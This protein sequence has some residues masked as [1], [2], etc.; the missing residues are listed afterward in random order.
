MPNIPEFRPDLGADQVH[1]ALKNSIETMDKAQHCAL[2]WFGEILRRELYRNLGFSTM[3]SYA[4][5]ALG[6]SPTRAGDFIRLARKLESLP[7][8]KEQVATGKL[9]YT[10]AREIAS[11]ADP[12]NEKGWV[13]V[14]QEKSR[15]ELETTVRQAKKLALQKRK[16]N[17]DQGELM[18]RRAPGAPPAAVP[19]RVG[20]ELTGAQYARYE[21][22]LAKIGHR[23]NKA[24]LL[25][26]MVEAL[27]VAD[28]NAPRGAF[29]DPHYQIHIHEC[30]TCAKAAVQTPQGEM[31]ITKTEVGAARCDAAIHQPGLRNTSTI[32]PRMRREVLARDRHRCRRKGCHHTRFLDIHHIIPRTAGGANDPENLITLCTSCHGLF[33]ERKGNPSAMLTEL[34]GV[35]M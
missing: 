30:P 35:E 23:G 4:M 9:G 14:A 26:D 25:L 34:I 11:V 21:A 18:P 12:T 8:V 19:V 1:I 33:H 20:F 7:R 5:E 13:K 15:R 17:P 32:P 16:E 2:L 24:D 29:A 31:E 3:R 10:K 27:L 22:M 6:F 28:K